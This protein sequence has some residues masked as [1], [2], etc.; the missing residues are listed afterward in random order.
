MWNPLVPVLSSLQR[1]LFG[2]T[3]EEVRYTFE[4]VRKEI[5]ATRSELEREIAEIRRRI[6]HV[7]SRLGEDRTRGP[8]LPVAE[9]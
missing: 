6:D 5:R 3:A 7:E 1:I 2:V 9:A 4:D 8:E